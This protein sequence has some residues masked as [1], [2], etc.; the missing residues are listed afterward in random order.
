MGT[1]DEHSAKALA[2]E[3]FAATMDPA[4]SVSAGWAM[5]MLFY[6]ALHHVQAY[7]VTQG[8]YPITHTHRDSSIRRDSNLGHIY[9]DYRELE[10][11]SRMAR[12]DTFPSTP[13]DVRGALLCL[14]RIKQTIEPLLT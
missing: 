4:I 1:Q 13:A 10:D 12:Y 11:L 14:A 8:K 7:F 5:T 2:N 9:V 3:V 6:A